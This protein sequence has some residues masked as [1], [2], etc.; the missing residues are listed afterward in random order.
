[1][2]S[3]KS[4]ESEVNDEKGPGKETAPGEDEVDDLCRAL[5]GAQQSGYSGTHKEGRKEHARLPSV[6]SINSH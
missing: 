1:M 2:H 3:E 5:D 6:E 4:D